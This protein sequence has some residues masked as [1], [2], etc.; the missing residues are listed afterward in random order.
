MFFG[1]EHYFRKDSRELALRKLA[2]NI[3]VLTQIKQIIED[4]REE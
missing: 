3:D 1:W 2:E 4:D